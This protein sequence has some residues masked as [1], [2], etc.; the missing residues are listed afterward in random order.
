M[1]DEDHEP[2]PRF[3]LANERTF[4]AWARTS[5]ALLAA[6][7]ALVQLAP[8]LGPARLRE[9]CAVVLAVLATVS[10][11]GGLVRWRSTQRAMRAGRPLRTGAL[12][13]VLAVGLV[14]V[15]VVLGVALLVEAA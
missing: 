8:D 13:A 6:A 9:A 12:P 1:P 5:L 2:D 15:A 11:A 14:V 10:A 4:L 3:T 7:V